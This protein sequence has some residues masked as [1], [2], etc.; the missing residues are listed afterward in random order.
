MW[1]LL[2]VTLAI[3]LST[4]STASPKPN[5]VCKCD[6]P[7]EDDHPRT[8]SACEWPPILYIHIFHTYLTNNPFFVTDILCDDMNELLG[9]EAIITQTKSLLAD[10][11]ARAANAFVSSPKCTPSRSAWLSGRFVKDNVLT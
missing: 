6:C 8:W 11:G 10:Q 9:D 5:F 4:S 2:P 1:S 7:N 3:S